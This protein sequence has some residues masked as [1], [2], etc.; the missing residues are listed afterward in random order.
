MKIKKMNDLQLYYL[1]L[2]IPESTIT[3][4]TWIYPNYVVRTGSSITSPHPHR[5]YNFEEFIEL[6]DRICLKRGFIMRGNEIDYERAGK[7]FITEFR[8]GKFGKI[9]L[10]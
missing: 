10:E 9:T 5:H 6:Y 8:N 2:S 1:Y 7:T 3:E 4:K